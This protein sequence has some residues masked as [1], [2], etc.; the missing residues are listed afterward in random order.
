MDSQNYIF[1]KA[2]KKILAIEFISNLAIL[3]AHIAI[4]WWIVTVGGVKDIA[5]YG[6]ALG[7]TSFCALPLL[8]PIGDRCEKRLVILL[9]LGLFLFGGGAV[10]LFAS[11]GI[12]HIWGLIAA[13]VITE[14]AH[15][16]IQ[17]AT[18][19]IVTELA[20]AEQLPAIVA[21]QKG[22][23]SLVRLSGP[24]LSGGVLAFLSISAALWLHVFFALLALGLSFFLPK[25]LNI[26]P[27]GSG[28]AQWFLELRQG[29]LAS[30][31]I[32]LERNWNIVN[33]VSWLFAGP[34]IGMLVPLKIQS[35][36]LGGWW[37]GYTEAGL[38]VGI[39]IGSFGL[40]NWLISRL[41]RYHVRVAAGIAQGLM[42]ALL[43]M[44]EN[45][46]LIVLL[47]FLTGISNSAL[48]LGGV[49][50]RMLARPPE[51][52][53]RMMSVSMASSRLASSGGPLLAGAC[54]M[55]LPLNNVYFL[56]GLLSAI[57]A[58]ALALTPGFKGFMSLSHAEV[59]NWYGREYP[60]AFHIQFK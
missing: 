51:F 37:F 2:I 57:V 17:P 20:D 56:F 30:W 38:G 14:L 54:L 13:G 32:P 29:A 16:L 6:A 52:R 10:A 33:A 26:K 9:G 46:L 28:F 3:I 23:Q 18:S 34:A 60:Q 1:T 41:G 47:F 25:S 8:S 55:Y 35:L 36:H 42:L 58:S 7:F 53:S 49:T 19:N 5:I 45:P 31:S 22:V 27:A 59:S 4:P 43:A 44:C 24:L 15:A 39:L 48:V 12:Y 21:K 40:S 50:H 11:H